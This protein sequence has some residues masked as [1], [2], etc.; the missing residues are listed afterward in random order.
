MSNVTIPNK[1][2]SQKFVNNVL[3]IPA[4]ERANSESNKSSAN[5]TSAKSN[6]KPRK[7]GFKVCVSSKSDKDYSESKHT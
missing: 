1:N 6:K 7:K 5:S 3:N 4:E 2:L